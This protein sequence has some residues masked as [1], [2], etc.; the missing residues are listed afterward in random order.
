MKRFVYHAPE[1]ILNLS[2]ERS[3]FPICVTLLEWNSEAPQSF[4]D[5]EPF[6]QEILNHLIWHIAPVQ[7]H[8]L[9]VNFLTP[10]HKRL[11]TFRWEPKWYPIAKNS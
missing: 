9:Y 1:N 2:T 6:A 10:F 8:I 7:D 11:C 5:Y 3:T 4:R